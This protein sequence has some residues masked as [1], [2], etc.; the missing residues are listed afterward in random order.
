MYHEGEYLNRCRLLNL[1]VGGNPGNQ[2]W[3]IADDGTPI[4]TWASRQTAEFYLREANRFLASHGVAPRSLFRC[5][6]GVGFI[7]V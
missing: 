4:E 6:P 1:R 7:E 5:L 2:W 3:I